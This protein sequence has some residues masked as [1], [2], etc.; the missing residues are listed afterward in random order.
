MKMLASPVARFI[1]N[2]PHWARTS[3]KVRPWSGRLVSTT[4]KSREFE[5]GTS[6]PML[7]RAER[8]TTNGASDSDALQAIARR[9]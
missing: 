9:R 4:C 1:R 7:H 6:D 3:R 2:F 5:S 8:Y